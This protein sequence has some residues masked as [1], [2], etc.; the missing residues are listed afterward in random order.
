MK[1][2]IIKIR[3]EANLTQEEFGKRI[4]LS[5][6]AVQSIEYGKN[7]PS[8][9]T[10]VRISE[11]FKYRLEWIKDGELPE[12]N[13]E[14]EFTT[15]INEALKNHG[16]FVKATFKALAKTPGGWNVMKTLV[17]NINLELQAKK[18]PAE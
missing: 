7:N 5:K 14:D 2:R 3:K 12:R 18:D 4:G 15:I 16:D 1:D 17:E 9:N 8:P 6:P 13:K 11:E 10:M